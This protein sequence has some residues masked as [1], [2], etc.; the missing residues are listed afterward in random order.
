MVIMIMLITGCEYD[1]TEPMW[2]KEGGN[3]IIPNTKISLIEPANVA[4]AGVN[5][6]TIHG[7]NFADSSAGNEVYFTAMDTKDGKQEYHIIRPEVINTTS[8]SITVVR[9]DFC[10]DSIKIKIKTEG[11]MV[12]AEDSNY[13]KIDTVMVRYGNIVDNV[14]IKAIV[15]DQEENVYVIQN[16]KKV[17]KINPNQEL[18]FWDDTTLSVIEGA[19]LHPDG[20]RMIMFAK[21][22]LLTQMDL[23]GS[24]ATRWASVFTVADTET[25]TVKIS[26]GDFDSQNNF[27]GGGSGTGLYRV[28]EGDAGGT[29]LGLYVD[30]NILY[31]HVDQGY[32]Y[33]LVDLHGTTSPHDRAIWR[34]SINSGTLGEAELV[35]DLAEGQSGIA[36]ANVKTFAI[37]ANDNIF[38][39]TVNGECAVLMFDPSD[40]SQDALYKNVIPS[41]CAMLRRGNGNY[42]YMILTSTGEN[43]LLRI[44]PGTFAT[45]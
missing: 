2:D 23:S 19:V 22:S 17:F 15:I 36:T 28:T 12:I 11:A 9:P 38:I 41:G 43:N 10:Y 25:S 33:I 45:Q 5:Y 35:F 6:I 24:P 34:H 1:V 32:L 4:P 29:P 39:G 37:M 8:S 3:K 16:T 14:V 26:T 44:D 20:N 21:D 42:L 7:E 18:V 13:Y 40:N 27:Y 30:D 31:I